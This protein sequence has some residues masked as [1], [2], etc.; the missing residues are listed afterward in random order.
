[1]TDQIHKNKTDA[2]KQIKDALKV[3]GVK[4]KVD[5]FNVTLKIDINPDNDQSANFSIQIHDDEPDVQITVEMGNNDATAMIDYESGEYDIDESRIPVDPDLCPDEFEI[6]AV[7]TQGCEC[8]LDS[9]PDK[10]TACEC[11]E[12]F[13]EHWKAD[14]KDLNLNPDFN[15][16]TVHK[17]IVNDAHDNTIASYHVN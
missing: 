4:C 13:A 6:L 7:N 2:I 14:A 1:M 11:A 5:E 15:Y 16:G 9:D 3:L 8:F 17:I 10:S 12:S